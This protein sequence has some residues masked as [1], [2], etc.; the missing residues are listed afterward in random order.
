MRV[1]ITLWV[2]FCSVSKG[3]KLCSKFSNTTTQLESL[4]ALPMLEKS[5]KFLVEQQSANPI[6]TIVDCITKIS[7]DQK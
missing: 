4:H 5:S 7:T 1:L 6:R 2:V 3:C